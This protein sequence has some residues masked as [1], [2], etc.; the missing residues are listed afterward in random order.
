[1]E[2][3]AFFLSPF[4]ALKY[5]LFNSKNLGVKSSCLSFELFSK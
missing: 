2:P 4:D 3:F 5:K 1:M